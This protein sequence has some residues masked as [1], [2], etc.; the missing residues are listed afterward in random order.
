[1]P[2]AKPGFR[3]R[4]S[5]LD[6][7]YPGRGAIKLADIVLPRAGNIDVVGGLRSGA[8]NGIGARRRQGHPEGL[9]GG[10]GA[11]LVNMSHNAVFIFSDEHGVVVRG[12]FK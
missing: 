12:I 11:T 5:R 6:E 9:P 3:E 8:G 10:I 2:L 4:L 1:M 7:A